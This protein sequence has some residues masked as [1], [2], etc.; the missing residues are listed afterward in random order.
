[1]DAALQRIVTEINN[2]PTLPQVVESVMSMVEDPT[3]TATQLAAI[4]SKDQALMSKVLKVVN[5]AY[6]GMPRKITTL[7]QATVI[8][9]FNTIKNLVLSASIFG[10]FDDHYSNRRFSRIKFWEHSIGTAVGARVL[11]R[12]IGLGNPEEL[13]VAGLVHDIGKVV[14]DE[15][16]HDDFLKILDIVETRPV[17]ILDAEK[18]VLSF[19]HPILGEWVATKWNLPQNLVTVIAYHHTPSLAH[20]YKKMVSV[21]HLAD[22]ISRIEGIGYGGDLQTPV[23]DPQSWE[24]L[25]IPAEELGELILKIKEEFKKATVFLAMAN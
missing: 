16:L 14:I 5:S 11:S 13:F 25:Q 20:D 12:R 18:E 17:R 15:Y 22:A 4:I 7:N 6:Y 1:M 3:T 8:L 9:G 24:T 23:I 10:A 21:V 2:L 19:G